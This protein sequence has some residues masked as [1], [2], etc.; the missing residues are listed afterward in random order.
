MKL[1]YCLKCSEIFNLDL[2][3]KKCRCGKSKGQYTDNLNA[4][5]KGPCLPLGIANDS[6]RTALKNQPE[7]GIGK[8]FT[9]FVIEKDCRTF[10]R[11]GRA[12][13]IAKPLSMEDI[14]KLMK[15]KS[16]A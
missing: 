1:L 16:E 15:N 3:E 4:W 7:T 8:E 11:K 10:V 9:A 12:P 14:L 5:F 13:K 2:S 6:F